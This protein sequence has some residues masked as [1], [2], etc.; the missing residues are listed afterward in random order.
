MA[1]TPDFVAKNADT[2]VAYLK[3]WQDVGRDFK[4]N[5]NG[6]GGIAFPHR[7]LSKAEVDALGIKDVVGGLQNVILTGTDGKVYSLILRPLL[8]EESE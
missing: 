7:A 3:A 4:E 5:P 1:A 6:E 8:P 2:V